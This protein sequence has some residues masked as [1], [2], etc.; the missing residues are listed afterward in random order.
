MIN[1]RAE[2][3]LVSVEEAGRLTSMSSWSWR[4]I[5][6]AGIVP[7]V[8]LGTRLLIPKKAILDHIAANTRPARISAVNR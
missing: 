3:E 8:K 1:E 2:V 7:T 6:A 5:A 4:K